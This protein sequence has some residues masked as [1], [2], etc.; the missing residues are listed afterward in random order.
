MRRLI[1]GICAVIVPASA[2]AQ[3][4]SLPWTGVYGGAN[5]GIGG[6]K[7][8]YK[9]NGEQPDGGINSDATMNTASG[10]L[11]GLQ[12]GYQYQFG[13]NIVLGIEADFQWSSIASNYSRVDM[14]TDY[15]WDLRKSHLL[16]FGT[17]RARAGYAFGNVL[18]YVTAGLAYGR[19]SSFDQEGGDIQTDGTF[20]PTTTGK[21]S[22]IKW[23]W[24]LGAG[25]EYAVNQNWRVRAEYLLIDLGDMRAVDHAGSVYSLTTRANV[26]R[27]GVNYAFGG[28]AGPNSAAFTPIP[29]W[30]NW[31][32][33]HAGVNFGLG[34]N[35]VHINYLEE[36]EGTRN[37]N[38]FGFLGGVEAGYDWQFANA[39]VLGGVVDWQATSISAYRK[40]LEPPPDPTEAGT[41]GTNGLKYRIQSLSNLRARLGYAIGPFL[42]Y[43][44][45]GIAMGQTQ[46]NQYDPSDKVSTQQRRTRNQTGF[47]AG[48]GFEYA[49]ATSWTVKA[50][51]LYYNLGQFSGFEV[52]LDQFKTG[53][54]FSTVRAGLN[55]RF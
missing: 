39:V 18:P 52:D 23:G 54:S 48:V 11:G 10:F 45:V 29:T 35:G 22:S 3:S 26:M 6:N 38:S 32:G 21:A 51:Y 7:F 47:T 25:I 27:L 53:I 24:A 50:D 33:F 20:E 43:A 2:Y 1:F 19:T 40:K 34:G 44:T 41:V 9:G 46:F 37:L 49:I 16:Y 42:P 55:Y 31:T 5:Y 14:R 12:A 15:E 28:V 30:Q 13:T 4:T 17:L 36:G 8:N